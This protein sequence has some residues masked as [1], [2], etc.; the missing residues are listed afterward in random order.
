M[1]IVEL[2]KISLVAKTAGQQPGSSSTLG[3]TNTSRLRNQVEEAKAEAVAAAAAA[4]KAKAEEEAWRQAFERK[5]VE[6]E[7]LFE[8]VFEAG[9]S[10]KP[11]PEP[12]PEPEP[13]NLF[14]GIWEVRLLNGKTASIH[15]SNGSWELYDKVYKLDL[16]DPLNPNFSWPAGTV[17]RGGRGVG[18]GC[19]IWSKV[20][21]RR[22]IPI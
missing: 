19:G 17:L 9:L 21:V 13:A 8:A 3:R 6:S 18:G 10:P 1:E 16:S 2:Q 5:S 11:S 4:T 14:D 7:K 12:E 20:I 15:I 22:K